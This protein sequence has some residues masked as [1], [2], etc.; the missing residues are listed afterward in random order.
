MSFFSFIHYVLPSVTHGCI[1]LAEGVLLARSSVC[2][3]TFS[4]VA[5]CTILDV[6]LAMLKVLTK[7]N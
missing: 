5:F 3:F 7:F 2:S 1:F 4:P 6:G